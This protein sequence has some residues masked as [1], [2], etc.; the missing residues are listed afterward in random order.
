MAS[1][2]RQPADLGRYLAEAIHFVMQR[3]ETIAD[4]NQLRRQTFAVVFIWVD[5]AIHAHHSAH[6]AERMITDWNRKYPSMTM[7]LSRIDLSE[8]C[9]EMWHAVAEWIGS[10]SISDIGH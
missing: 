3:V 4:L 5:W 1:Q 10:Q 8:Q 2:S 9:S 7:V 6:T